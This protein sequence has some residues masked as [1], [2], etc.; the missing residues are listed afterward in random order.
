MEG[1]P[2]KVSVVNSISLTIRP[3]FRVFIQIY[4]RTHS[5]GGGDQQRDNDNIQ[6]VHNISRDTEGSLGGTL[7]RGQ[8]F[9]VNLADTFDKY[10][11]Y[12]PDQQKNGHG[13]A[14][15]DDSGQDIV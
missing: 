9:P 14:H 15:I 2:D 6:R 8:E 10:I 1:I 3:G 12:D 13:S 5:D 11:S 7:Y 4:R